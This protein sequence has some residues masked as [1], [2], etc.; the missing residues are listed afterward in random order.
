MGTAP[1]RAVMEAL[2]KRKIYF[3][4]HVSKIVGKPDIVFRRNKS[5]SFY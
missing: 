2:K 1:E 5:S 3:A 4:A